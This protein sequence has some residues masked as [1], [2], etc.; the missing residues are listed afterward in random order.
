MRKYGYVRVGAIVNKLALANPLEN[1]KE[2]IKNIKTAYQK[3]IAIVVT[4]ELALT[5]YTCADLFLQDK[6][7][8]DS[9]KGLEEILKATKTLVIIPL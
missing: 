6:L 2:L 7:I 8:K 9:L 1:A 4:P 3:D 5:G